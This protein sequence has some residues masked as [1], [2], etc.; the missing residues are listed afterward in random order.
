LSVARKRRMG[1]DIHKVLS[2]RR[3]R[4]LKADEAWIIIHEIPEGNWTADGKVLHLEDVSEL[5]G[6]T[7][8]S[9]GLRAKK[10]RH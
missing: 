2:A 5:M 4:N 3:G 6:L 10:L 8:S 7:D 9:I 1:L